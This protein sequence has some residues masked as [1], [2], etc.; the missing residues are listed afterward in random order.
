MAQLDAGGLKL[1]RSPNAISDLMSDTIERFRP[2]AEERNVSLNGLAAPG[3]DPVYIDARQISRVLTN[4]VSNAVRY[5]PPGGRVTLHAYPTLRRRC[6]RSDGH[7]RGD[8]S[9]RYAAY[10]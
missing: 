7:G 9:R 4:L 5:T 10:L 8:P 1:D 6:S 2:M 3:V